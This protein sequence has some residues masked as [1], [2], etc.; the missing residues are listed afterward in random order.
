MAVLVKHFFE[1][2]GVVVSNRHVVNTGTDAVQKGSESSPRLWV[3]RH[4][5][6]T[7]RSTVKV[8]ADGKQTSFALR[9][10]LLHVAPLT[11]EFERRLDGFGTR[12]HRQNHFVSECLGDLFGKRCKRRVVESS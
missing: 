7:Q 3:G 1:V 4:G 6:D 11:S 10:T 9:N 2:I 5:D 8:A 12:V